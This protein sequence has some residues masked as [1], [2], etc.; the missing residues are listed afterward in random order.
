[1][2]ETLRTNL[3][4]EIM[5][6]NMRNPFPSVRGQD[7]LTFADSDRTEPSYLTHRQVQ[8]YLVH[9]TAK[10]KLRRLIKFNTRVLR[11]EHQHHH[12][13]Q[14]KHSEVAREGDMGS[15]VGK[16]WSSCSCGSDSSDSSAY[17]GNKL[18]S[19]NV[20]NGRPW[21]VRYAST[22][23]SACWAGATCFDSPTG[24]PHPSLQKDSFDAVV[25]CNG[26]YQ[27]PFIPS[28]KG[29]FGFH[30]IL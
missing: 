23:Q 7:S 26:H 3:P 13:H 19:A 16:N 30:K 11:V 10:H 2:Y 28:V 20:Q 6:F 4:K 14:Q 22:V 29:K 12:Q 9:F 5:A 8:E 21:M 15:Q 1:M 24:E 17:S 25:V 18:G 27:V